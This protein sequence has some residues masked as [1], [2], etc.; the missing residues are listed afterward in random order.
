MFL[1]PLKIRRIEAKV[2]EITQNHSIK[3]TLCFLMSHQWWPLNSTKLLSLRIFMSTKEGKCI[4]L[5][6]IHHNSKLNSV[7]SQKCI[8]LSKF[9]P[10]AINMWLLSV[11]WPNKKVSRYPNLWPVRHK[12]W[13]SNLGRLGF[14]SLARR[15]SVWCRSTN[16]ITKMWTLH[17]FCRC[18]KNVLRSL[19]ETYRKCRTGN[20]Q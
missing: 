14:L 13:R 2:K 8:E 3:M 6:N 18:A 12:L 9:I 5:I 7:S 1:S 4:L 10:A 17:E 20:G 11:Q 19:G 16:A 15:F